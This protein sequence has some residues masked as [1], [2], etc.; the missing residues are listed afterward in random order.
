MADYSATRDRVEHYFDRSATKVWERLTSDAPVS[1]IRE[2]VRQ[3][4]DRMRGIMLS[5]L[6]VDL[7]GARVLDAGCGTGLMTAEL[8]ARGADVVAVDISPQL[9]GIAEARLAEGLR[10]RVTFAAGDMTDPAHGRFDYVL[11]MDSLIYYATPDIAAALRKIGNRTAQRIVFTV[12]PKT[13]FLMAFFGL[14]KL[15]PRADRSPVM[16]PQAFPA[17]VRAVPNLAKI[18]RVTSGFYISECLEMRP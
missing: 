6:P 5:R 7:R 10:A 9:I 12:A 8:A 11:A 3:G 15:F 16:V 1:R 4:R 13:P 14:G 17:L 2:T 18:D